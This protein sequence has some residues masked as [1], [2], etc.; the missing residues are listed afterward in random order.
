MKAK[1]IINLCENDNVITGQEFYEQF[2]AYFIKKMRS[3]D[4]YVVDEESELSAETTLNDGVVDKDIVAVVW[5]YGQELSNMI[6]DSRLFK[7]MNGFS[8]NVFCENKYL[9]SKFAF[10]EIECII[11]FYKIKDIL[12]RNGSTCLVRLEILFSQDTKRRFIST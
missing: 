2:K 3:V 1:E 7:S 5:A 9:W 12:S 11:K 8:L 4:L 10:L 6:K